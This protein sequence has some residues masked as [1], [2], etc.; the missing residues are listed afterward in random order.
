LS[1]KSAF[2]LHIEKILIF[3]VWVQIVQIDALQFVVLIFV[4]TWGKPRSCKVRGLGG[5][6]IVVLIVGLFDVIGGVGTIG[7]TCT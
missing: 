5:T 6:N 2:C 4:I 7:W 3:R 1:I